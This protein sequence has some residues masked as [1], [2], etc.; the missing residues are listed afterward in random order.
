MKIAIFTDTY[1][2]QVNGVTK[3][4]EK[5]V[6]YL[7]D[8]DIDY[9]LY[10]PDD[11]S[12][13]YNDKIIR[14]F[15]FKFFLYPECRLSLPN[16]F[17]MSKQ[18]NDFKPDLI[19][20]VTP[21]NIGLCGLKY[22]RSNDIPLVSSYHTNIPEYLEYFN[23]KLLSNISWDFFR[24]FHSFCRKNYCPSRATLELLKEKGIRDLEI[25]G[26]G[27]DTEKFSPNHRD[28][29]Y[30]KSLNINDK[31]VFLYVGRISPEKDL[32]VFMNV[33]KR[34]NKKYKDKI[35]FLMVGNGPMY[36]ELNENSPSNMTFT[37]FKRGNELSKIYASSDIFM[38][39]SSTE[40]YGNVIIESMASG[41][42]T[43]GCYAR[44]VKENLI[45]GF[46]G[47]ACGIRNE[48]DFYNAAE[49]LIL[50][51]E[52]RKQLSA[53]GRAYTKKRS[54][55]EVFKKLLNSYRGIVDDDR[56]KKIREVSA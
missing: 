35:H 22:A 32:D 52:I 24:W 17:A 53:T 55:D 46:N 38:F 39:P 11:G 36:D 48:D 41:L 37:G 25:W 5:Y 29:E 26:R 3:T 50:N 54:W 42:A 7:E 8:N 23:L 19:H 9:R 43:I 15:S 2:P 44:G 21:F 1:L 18:L 4:L 56:Y 27:I 14:F 34:L 16:Y 45:D 30:R 31:I 20:I 49:K 13:E 47:C 51:P 28:V 33:A 12:K 40:T 10:A 6:N